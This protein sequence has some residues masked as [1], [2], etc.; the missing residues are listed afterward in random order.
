MRAR[1]S[2]WFRLTL[3]LGLLLVPGWSRVAALGAITVTA[4]ADDITANGN[5]TL[6]EAI[7]AANTNAAVDAC[8]AGSGADVITLPAGLYTI[9]I[10]GGFENLNQTGDLDVWSD[11]TIQGAGRDKTTVKLDSTVV[12]DRILDLID[13]EKNVQIS[14]ITFR[15]GN[16]TDEYNDE[17]E[18]EEPNG[19]AIR[20]RGTLTV[21]NTGFFHNIADGGASGGGGG[22]YN[23][24]TLIG[25][26]LYFEANDSGGGGGS[27]H[28]TGVLTV[29]NSRIY[30]NRGYGSGGIFNELTGAAELHNV[31]FIENRIGLGGGAAIFNGGSIKITSSLFDRNAGDGGTVFNA[32][33]LIMDQVT[34]TR[35][36]MG[37]RGTIESYRGFLDVTRS[38]F[39]DNQAGQSGAIYLGEEMEATISDSVFEDNTG[40]QSGGAIMVD[41]GTLVL[42]NTTI[43]GNQSYKGGGIYNNGGV[44]EIYESALSGNTGQAGGGAIYNIGEIIVE[45][46]TISGNEGSPGGGIMQEDGYATF[47][48]VTISAN[49]YSGV[50]ALAGTLDF[51]N[52]ILAGNTA[53]VN[54]DC[55]ADLD[56]TIE[57]RGGNVVGIANGCAWPLDVGDVVGFNYE[58]VDA[59]LG[60]L[61]DN[62]GPTRT[63]ALLAGSPA[64]DLAG[65]IGCPSTDQRG[66][67]RPVGDSCD[68]GSY[69]GSASNLMQYK[70]FMPSIGANR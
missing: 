18:Y 66:V 20:N 52:S 29:T 60:P 61:A 30:R 15:D 69:E 5:C 70:V 6:R 26:G 68:S 17:M 35:N 13:P 27:I 1:I 64:I 8:P 51:R 4:V 37:S 7:M 25:T 28:N 48:F 50:N 53:V 12:V 33:E 36:D 57:S 46:S 45:N 41:G 56:V 67:D 32:G 9:T 39:I 59:K 63:H 44:V 65:V 54:P 16:M 19:G 10:P 14:G 58:P 2:L 40:N 42:R 34:F 31:D 11:L 47:D 62:G 49:R 38:A 43:R 55:S 3:C 24:G 23:A 22:I 21:S